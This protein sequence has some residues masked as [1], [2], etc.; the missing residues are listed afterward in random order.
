MQ[1]V[2]SIIKYFVALPKRKI[3]LYFR[4][5]KLFTI[6]VHACMNIM[7]NDGLIVYYTVKATRLIIYYW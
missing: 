3:L 7:Y 4:R 2:E 1:E 6:R 5:N